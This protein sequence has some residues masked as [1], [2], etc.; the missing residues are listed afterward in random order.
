MIGV[1]MLSVDSYHKNKKNDQSVRTPVSERI[2]KKLDLRS[3]MA[4][5]IKPADF[6]TLGQRVEDKVDQFSEQPF[7]SYADRS[8]T[9]KEVDERVNQYANTLLARGVRPGDVCAVALENRPELIFCW[10]ALAKIGAIITL[11]NYHLVGKP[12]V[13]VLQATQTKFVLVG[14]ECIAPFLDT[15]EAQ[16]WP[17]W[18]VADAENPASATDLERFDQTFSPQVE[19]ASLARPDAALREGI[20]AE[21][22]ML[23]IFTSGTTG[24]PKAAR[25]SHMR[26]MSSGDVM[27]VTL[28]TDSRDVFYCCL[29][30]YHGAAATSVVSTALSSGASIVIR[31]RFSASRFWT[32]VRDHGVTVFQYVGEICRYLLNRPESVEEKNNS[33]RCM[34]G[35]GLTSDTWQRW[36]KRFGQLDVY[37][38]WGATEANTA[39]INLDNFIGSCGRVPD[40]NKTNLRLLRIDEETQQHVRNAQGFY[41]HCEPGEV[42]E[43]VGFIVDSPMTG[44]GRFEGY[45]SK[46]ATETK[47]LR[48]V[49]QQGDA[50]WSS[51]DLLRYDTDGYCYFV[52]RVGDT[53]RWKSENVSTQEVATE[54]GDFAGMEFINVYGVTV[55]GNEGRAGM[56]LVVMQQ[57]CTF[58][59]QAFYQ[60]VCERLPHYAR[61]VF[62]RVGS[63]A[64]MTTTFKHRKI[65]LQKQ[66]Y[67]PS[68]FADTLYVKDDS[69]AT[70]SLY[71]DEV[72]ARNALL[73]FVGGDA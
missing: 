6:Y 52:D 56:A 60:F 28:E 14:E 71:S 48:N 26:W 59:P 72:L 13:H 33:L 55:P 22:D 20:H 73:P 18:L 47:I 45:T 63:Q 54:L 17:Q 11:V 42:G 53:F 9:Y 29:P 8:L 68:K 39:T 19:S 67:D 36:I 21:D 37:E 24:L 30:L 35:A 57:G 49:F 3:A 23:Y 2:Q 32:D 16:Q 41:V 34:L 10:F 27:E 64:D 31:R 43:A 44:A 46:E 7:L 51:G 4:S 12:L 25:Y 65:D 61:P 15:P 40:W 62:V 38:G 58:D 66:G 5:K 1:H 70:Y 50:W 69:A